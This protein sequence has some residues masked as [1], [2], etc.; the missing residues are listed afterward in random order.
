MHRL[1][2][3][4]WLRTIVIWIYLPPYFFIRA[5]WPW[6]Q[7]PSHPLSKCIT[8]EPNSHYDLQRQTAHSYYQI[9]KRFAI[10]HAKLFNMINSWIIY[11]R[12]SSCHYVNKMIIGSSYGIADGSAFHLVGTV[13]SVF[14]IR[15]CFCAF[16]C[17]FRWMY[18]LG[19]LLIICY[20]HRLTSGHSDDRSKDCASSV[21]FDLVRLYFNF[22]HCLHSLESHPFVKSAADEWKRNNTKNPILFLIIERK[23][24]IAMSHIVFLGA[25]KSMKCAG[26]PNNTPIAFQHFISQ[27]HSHRLNSWWSFNP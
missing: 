10:E 14:I 27:T 3:S 1:F 23:G 26:K 24:F 12:L 16:R 2:S 19:W 7:K 15:S 13:N 20:C 6:A 18:F 8:N 11:L 22:L 5:L 9:Y 17:R 25:S 21:R 4:V